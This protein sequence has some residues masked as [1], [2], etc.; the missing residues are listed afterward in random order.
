M[1]RNRSPALRTNTEAY[2]RFSCRLKLRPGRLRR[3]EDITHS[4]DRVQHAFF[5]VYFV[6][7]AADQHIDYVGLRIETVIPDMLEDHGLGD[8]SA[9]VPH[10]EF[11]ERKLA[12]LQLDALGT[13][14]HL[15]G[16]KVQ[17][18]VADLQAGRF[19]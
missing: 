18:Q 19:G 9:R 7:N 5:P 14:L 10:Q 4:A 2:H 12:R 6:A 16:Q 11:K 8:D 13:A 3:F 1:A 15:A 17:A